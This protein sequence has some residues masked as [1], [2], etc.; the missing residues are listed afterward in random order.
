MDDSCGAAFMPPLQAWWQP[1]EPW[2]RSRCEQDKMYVQD[3]LAVHLQQGDDV[4]RLSSW[5]CPGLGSEIF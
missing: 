4:H 3:R 2:Y 1:L 5:S